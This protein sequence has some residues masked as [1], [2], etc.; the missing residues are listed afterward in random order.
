ML[1]TKLEHVESVEQLREFIGN[2][3]KVAVCCGRMGPMCIPVYKIMEALTAQYTHVAFFDMDFDIPAAN[4]IKGLPQCVNFMGLPFT[5]Y[6]KKGAV[7]AATSSIQTK[8]QVT[9]LLDKHFAP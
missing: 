6:Y 3:E 4:Q 8:A 9:A 7:V 5:V 2:N 1:Q